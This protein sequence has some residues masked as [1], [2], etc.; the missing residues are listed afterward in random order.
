MEIY[1]SF[2]PRLEAML[3]EGTLKDYIAGRVSCRTNDPP[4]NTRWNQETEDDILLYFAG[5]RDPQ[6]GKR[7]YPDELFL[8]GRQLL[9]ELDDNPEKARDPNLG[10]G[11]SCFLGFGDDKGSNCIAAD[12]LLR[13]GRPNVPVPYFSE[14]TEHGLL[15]LAIPWPPTDGNTEQVHQLLINY[16]QKQGTTPDFA[17]LAEINL[18]EIDYKKGLEMMSETMDRVEDP[19]TFG[20]AWDLTVT[21]PP[22]ELA[23]DLFRTLDKK[24]LD[25]FMEALGF[26]SAD[27]RD[28]KPKEFRREIDKLRLG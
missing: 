19:R 9:W 1:E 10:W 16:I 14:H 25:Y 11:L 13:K 18:L 5:K 12:L 20:I 24:H 2:R 8:A 22:A 7:Y 23:S 28:D 17:Q 26:L 21:H 6:P 27:F 4:I 3:T 15:K